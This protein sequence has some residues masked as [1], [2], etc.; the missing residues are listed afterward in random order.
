MPIPLYFAVN[1]KESV[2]N[3]EI[4]LAQGG[5]GV[6]EDGTARLPRR[7][8][9]DA[10]RIIDDSVLPSAE[11][12]RETLDRLAELCTNGCFLDFERPFCAL[13]LTLTDGLSRRLGRSAFLALPESLAPYAPS[14]LP[15]VRCP[16]L[17]NGWREFCRQAQARHP[18]GWMLELTPWSETFEYREHDARGELPAALCAYV[19]TDGTLHYYDTRE[20]I[21][22]KLSAAESFGCRAAIGILSE[23]RALKS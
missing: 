13:Q 19:C 23:L 2:N 16:S 12:S 20:S 14:A 9:P 5:Y 8:I 7:Q 18:R 22:A 1:W 15:V 6:W 17:C 11:V 10:P 21:R 3:S 4:L